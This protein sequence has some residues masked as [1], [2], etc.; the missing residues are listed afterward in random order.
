VVKDTIKKNLQNQLTW[1]HR[2]TQR[3]HHQPGSLH[4]TDLG[5]LHTC[6]DFVTWSSCRAPNRG[7]RA[8]S[9]TSDLL[10]F[11]LRKYTLGIQKIP[12]LS[13]YETADN[14]R[15]LPKTSSTSSLTACSSFGWLNCFSALKDHLL[16]GNGFLHASGSS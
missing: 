14:A 2:S 10:L 8:W 7:S 6:Y 9:W 3:L 5:P 4:Q 13:F 11:L 15:L 12:F 16:N 1:A